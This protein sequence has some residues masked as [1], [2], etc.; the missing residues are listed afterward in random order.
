MESIKSA[1][2]HRGWTQEQLAN[3]IGVKRSVISKYESGSISPSMDTLRSIANALGVNTISLITGEKEFSSFV[4]FAD[5][6]LLQLMKQ[7]YESDKDFYSAF[8]DKKISFLVI[9]NDTDRRLMEAYLALNTNG[10]QKAVE[11]VEELTEIPKYQRE[12][13]QD[14]PTTPTD[15][16]D[17]PQSESLSEGPQEGK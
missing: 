7:D 17:A 1:R 10:Q 15:G 4:R 11:R 3:A 5:D 16:K 14:M 13:P 6:G 2:K 12:K 8:F 9:N